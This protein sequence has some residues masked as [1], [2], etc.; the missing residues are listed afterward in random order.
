MFRLLRYFSV[1]SLVAFIIVTL[2]LT[3]LYRQ[4]ALDDLVQLR[5]S[6]NVVSTQLFSNTIWLDFGEWV[7][8]SS[9]RPIEDVI[10]D[11]EVQALTGELLDKT[12][13]STVVK[14]KVYNTNGFTVYSTEAAELGEYEGDDNAAFAGALNGTVSSEMELED[15]IVSFDSVLEERYIVESYVPVYNTSGEIEGV[16]EIYD[17][18]T[19]FVEDIRTTQSRV[20]LAV[21]TV[22][23]GLYIALFLIV[24]RADRIL[25]RQS[26]EIQEQNESLV[27]ANRELAVTRRQAEY[28]NHLKSQFLSTMSH[29]LRTPLNA[30]VGYSQI[31]LAGMAGA[32][33]D[34]QSGFQERI[35]INAKHLLKLI[36]EVLDL[37][38]IEAGRL[39]IDKSAFNL[40]EAL[41]T[42]ELQNRGLAEDKQLAFHIKVDER[43]PDV[44]VGDEGR[45]KQVVINLISNAI[46]FTDEGSITLEASLHDQDNWR[47]AI[48][49]TGIGIPSH[50][51]EH[52]FDEFR[53]VDPT[54]ER[55]GTGLGLAIVRR[56]V[57]MMGGNIRVSSAV[58][59]GSTF[60]VTLPLDTE[61]APEADP[62]LV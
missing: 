42:V 29:E 8:E 4:T 27:K 54:L 25:K 41:N 10:T 52:I 48:Q 33:T 47:I 9:A 53:Q 58:G 28:A 36:N 59:Q 32:M 51:Q 14:V 26:Q 2:I 43:L 6:S 37:S 44:I 19:R 50:Q 21:V 49:D 23:G 46:K 11:P 18:A 61:P 20:V 30:I 24:S 60:T 7:V 16:F 5:E 1:T 22:L 39:E 3:A 15:S 62:L 31:Q 34:E 57:L 13:G 55:G 35:L 40:R 12:R 38:K 17:D 56:L 45:I